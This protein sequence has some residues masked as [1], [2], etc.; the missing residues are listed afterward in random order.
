MYQGPTEYGYQDQEK[1]DS[2][3]FILFKE[4]NRFSSTTQQNNGNFI[5]D[6]SKGEVVFQPQEDEN[7]FQE[8]TITEVSVE[9]DLLDDD[10]IE[11]PLQENEDERDEEIPEVG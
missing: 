7:K 9:E 1:G 4:R 6:I 8:Q 5:D 3:G 10:E 11:E 2:Q